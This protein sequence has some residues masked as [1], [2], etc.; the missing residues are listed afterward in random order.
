M[1]DNAFKPFKDRS[2]E[3]VRIKCD[4]N[5]YTR[6]TILEHLKDHEVMKLELLKERINILPSMV[7]Q[8]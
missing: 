8:M 5:T 4:R 7:G 6:N 1:P 3:S 2:I